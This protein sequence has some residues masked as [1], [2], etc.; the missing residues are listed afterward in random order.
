MS[1]VEKLRDSVDGL[2]DDVQSLTTV[3]RR[4]RRITAVLSFVCVA[5]V[6]VVFG[7]VVTFQSARTQATCVRGWANAYAART[8]ALYPAA[9]SRTDTLDNLIR[10]IPLQDRAAFE[11]ALADYLKASDA[12]SRAA[13]ENPP[14][15][16]PR[17]TC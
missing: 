15:T 10:T 3:V 2:R 8:A 17:Y 1:D 12:Y 5:I 16:A 7:M 6:L 4:S 14:P 13:A 11:A 9:T